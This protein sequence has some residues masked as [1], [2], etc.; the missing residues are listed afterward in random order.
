MKAKRKRALTPTGAAIERPA[1]LPADAVEIWNGV[2][3][4]LEDAGMSL[5]RIDAHA[6][7]FYASC[8]QGIKTATAAGDSKLVARFSRDAIAW[9][10]QIGATPAARARLGLR[11]PDK[12]ATDADQWAELDAILRQP[13]KVK[14]Q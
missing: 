7:A 3:E 6:I 2:L 10:N 8:I 5:E 14:P 4:D 11:S 1:W 12:K 13:R 9:G